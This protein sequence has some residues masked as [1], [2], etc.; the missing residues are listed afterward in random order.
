M[1][2]AFDN[3]LINR[4]DAAQERISELEG[5]SIETSQTKKSK[6]IKTIKNKKEHNLQ[7]LWGNY[8]RYNIRVMGASEEKKDRQEEKK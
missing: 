5:M 6:R 8:K 1:K 2:N 3:G 7:E 4:L